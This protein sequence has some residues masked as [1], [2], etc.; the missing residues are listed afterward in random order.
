MTT[1]FSICNTKDYKILVRII[2]ESY[3][4]ARQKAVNAVNSE[5]T[6]SNWETG[7]YIVKYEQKGH[8]KA[9]Y[10]KELLKQ[11]SKDLTK[12]Y[13]RGFSRSGLVYMRLFY[14]KNPKWHIISLQNISHY[15]D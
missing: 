12:K 10:G 9:G 15:H 1:C 4:K 11:L 14:M 7:Q 13:D 8:E 5:L 6:K 3:L 2:G